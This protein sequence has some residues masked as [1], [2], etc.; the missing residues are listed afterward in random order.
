MFVNALTETGI[1]AFALSPA[2]LFTMEDREIHSSH[3]EPIAELLR[4][5]YVPVLHGDTILDSIR[6][7]TIMSSENSLQAC[8]KRL[9]KEYDETMVIYCMDTDGIL[10]EEGNTVPE[11]GRDQK[12]F[13]HKT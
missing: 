3:L 8:L 4:Q 12:V 11:F 13:I 7:M 5:G 10:D 6:G 9:G 2:S 1:P